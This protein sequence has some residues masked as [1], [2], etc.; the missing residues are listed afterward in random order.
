M[1]SNVYGW[2]REYALSVLG[3]P[4]NADMEMVKKA[5]HMLCKKFHPDENKD[6]WALDQYL[7]VQQA[8][9]Y[10]DH[11]GLYQYVFQDASMPF[12]GS[13]VPTSPKTSSRIIGTGTNPESEK[14][15]EKIRRS[16][17][18]KQSLEKREKERIRKEK[19]MRKKQEERSK[20][21]LEAKRK[22]EIESQVYRIIE[23]LQL[24][25]SKK[26][27]AIEAEK[28]VPFPSKKETEPVDNEVYARKKAFEAFRK[29]EERN[30][31]MDQKRIV[32]PFV[33]F[34]NET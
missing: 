20:K 22:R 9:E 23:I 25:D 27:E 18:E 12:T 33:S 14:R 11:V 6:S 28:I 19:E 34:S 7:L 10:L 13:G 32:D 3:L 8:Y 29:Y 30:Q 31:E 26:R 1:N 2:S 16:S 17:V 21:I 24:L 15:F 4:L 5:Y